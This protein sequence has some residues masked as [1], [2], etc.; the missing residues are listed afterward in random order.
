MPCM[1]SWSWTWSPMNV[2]A[3]VSSPPATSRTAASARPVHEMS[4]SNAERMMRLPLP[5]GTPLRPR[6]TYDAR[7]AR[8]G[9][10][11]PEGGCRRDLGPAGQTSTQ[12]GPLRADRGVVAVPGVDDG[13]VGQREQPGADRLLDDAAVG[14]RPAGRAGTAVE[15]GVP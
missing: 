11:G 2:F 7:Q 14:V 4:L 13:V 5:A 10:A 1:V 6:S 12:Q 15:E 9:Q 8:A 3:Q